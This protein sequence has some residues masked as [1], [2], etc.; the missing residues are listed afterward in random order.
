MSAK[1]KIAVKFG[2]SKDLVESFKMHQ[3]FRKEQNLN[4]ASLD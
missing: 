1:W 2:S 4:M 3:S